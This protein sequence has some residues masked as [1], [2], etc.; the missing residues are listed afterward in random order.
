MHVRPAGALLDCKDFRVNHDPDYMQ[1]CTDTASSNARPTTRRSVLSARMADA[2]EEARE[3]L[4][5][6]IEVTGLSPYKLAQK[7]GVA[8]ST[9][10]RPL[11]DPEFK[12]IPKRATLDKIA[13]AAGL[14]TP[15]ISD[16]SLRVE[17]VTQSVPILGEVRAGTWTEIQDDARGKEA[18]LVHLPEYARAS[19]FA[20]RVAGRSMDLKYQE[21]TIVI[22]ASPA[23]TGVRVGDDVIV[24]RQ[25]N[26]MAETTLKEV[27]QLSGGGYELRPCSS[28]ASFQPIA[29]DRGREAQ[30]G[31]E[32]IGVVIYSISPSRSGRGPLVILPD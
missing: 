9:I 29:L 17:P 7:A 13:Q 23:E 10:T 14:T 31:P 32:I 21:G 11:N 24:R 26:G 27:A 5:L 6:A 18:V 15:K 28:D 4:R 20:V 1:E 2:V 16:P 22:A 8:P 25:R 3:F 30:D 19:L 12:F